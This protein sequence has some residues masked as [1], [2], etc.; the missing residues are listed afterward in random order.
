VP[1]PIL[2]AG[3]SNNQKAAETL[4]ALNAVIAFPTTIFIGKDGKVKYIHTGFSGPGTGKH[5]DEFVAWFNS[6]VNSL[7]NDPAITP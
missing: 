7:L 3:E 5:F 1:Y 6:T 4:P 2:I